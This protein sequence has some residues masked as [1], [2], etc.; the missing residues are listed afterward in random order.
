MAMRVM[1][2]PHSAAESSW[3]IPSRSSNSPR[4]DESGSGGQT[5]ADGPARKRFQKSTVASEASA[6]RPPTHTTSSA[7]VVPEPRPNFTSRRRSIRD[8]KNPLGPRLADFSPSKSDNYAHPFTS[9]RTLDDPV[10]QQP[11]RNEPTEGT[12]NALGFSTSAGLRDNVE[13]TAA[14]FDF[15]A[16]VS[17]DELH[18][19][20]APNELK[21]SQFPAPGGGGTI[22]PNRGPVNSSNAPQDRR[23]GG[24]SAAAASAAAAT[25]LGRSGS[26][27]RRQTAAARP[28]GHAAPQN[29]S[30]TDSQAGS[31]LS[32]RSRRQSHFVPSS[33]AAA[34]AR[35]PRKSIG[36]GV[37]D[38]A[39]ANQP[40]HPSRPS[41]AANGIRTMS[42]ERATRVSIG[43]TATAASQGLRL[44]TTSRDSKARSLQP[45]PPQD[46]H[47]ASSLTPDRARSSFIVTARSPGKSPSRIPTSP[48]SA[49]KRLSAMPVH[50]TGLG[51][52]T[53]S[54]TD[55][56]RMKRMSMMPEPPPMPS[57]PSTPP[58]P[59][60][61]APSGG[62]STAHSP[63]L[64]PRKSVTP[65]S[66]RNTPD[67]H[68]KSFGS[69]PSNASHN[70]ATTTRAATGSQQQHR[71]SQGIATSRLPTPKARNVHS[72]AGGDED[73]E[74]PPVPAIPKAYESPKETN[75]PPFFSA[76]KS[77]LPLESGGPPAEYVDRRTAYTP[78]P[79]TT[80]R[81]SRQ[82]RGMAAGPGSDAEGK[83]TATPGPARK[84][85]QP[86][87]LPPLNVLPLSTPTVA[88]VAALHRQGSN[89]AEAR[90][91]TPP[92][93]LTAKTPS[94]PM[95]A[96]KVA[97][98]SQSHRD[99]A[100][101]VQR[102]TRAESAALQT[103]N[104][105][106][107]ADPAHD[108][109]RSGRHTMTPFASSSL[110]KS[111]ADSGYLRIKDSG[112]YQPVILG[113]EP[114]ASRP[115]GPRPQAS[116]RTLKDD[117]CSPAASPTELDT[118]S[119][120][121]S[122]R[123]R[124]SMGF[125]KSSSKN[126]HAGLDREADATV[127]PPRHDDMPPPRLPASATWSTST[128]P[129]P[130]PSLKGT[131]HLQTRRR[132]GSLS[133]IMNGHSRI[134]S[135]SWTS[136]ATTRTPKDGQPPTA[137]AAAAE[138][139]PTP[140]T[141]SSIM[142]PVHKMLGSKSSMTAVRPKHLDQNLDADD[143]SAEEEMR[144]L[145]SKRKNFEA[146][147]KEVDELR[148]RAV[149]RERIAP[150][151]ALR[152]AN[153]NIF[154]R[155]EIIDYKDIYFCGVPNAKKHV[156]DL[157][158]Q[159][160]NFGYDDDRGDYNIVNGDHLAYR[161]EI[162]DI[163][164]KGSF[165]QVVRCV[166]H[167]TG[168]LV[169]IKIIRNKKRF[170]QQALVE[171]SI[172]QKL[173]EWVSEG[174]PLGAGPSADGREQD[175]QNRHSMVSFTQSFYFRGH[176]C[177]STELLGMNLYE[178]IKS[179]NFQGFSLKLIRRFTKQ[180]LSSL[181]LLKSHRVIHCDLKPENVLLAHPVH[182]E[183]KVIDFGS[184]CFENEKVYTY[185]Q[186]RFYRSPEVI[187][188]MTYGLPIDMWSVGCILAELHTGYPIFPGENEQEQLACIMEIFGPPEKHL[189]ERST[190]K[191]LFFDSLGK[192]R[193]TVS[194]KGR[195]RRPSSK[196]LQ[197]ALKCDDDAFLDFLTKCLRWDP[198]R[199]LKP[200]EAMMHEFVTR[201]KKGGRGGRTQQ[202]AGSTPVKRFNSITTLSGSRPLPE[203]PATSFKM[204][205]ARSRDAAVPGGGP[206]PAKASAVSAA[207]RQSTIV[208][209]VSTAG[210]KRSST[211]QNLSSSLPRVTPRS[212]SNRGELAAAAATVATNANAVSNPCRE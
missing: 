46:P 50:A 207:K 106:T 144:K 17:F 80:D 195:R 166:D 133:N 71:Y 147:A 38:T 145:A 101:P 96:S 24:A 148:R 202:L 95:T 11:P 69:G 172:L 53:I 21:L 121:S 51:A 36:P 120:G 114:R 41:L 49:S 25:R 100:T 154:E 146:A 31:S 26:L 93:R 210:I 190:R 2:Q 13:N 64:I 56:R 173:R 178:F 60:L 16:S 45:P 124:L 35:Q 159:T 5:A 73:E 187:L 27:L 39:L 85:S 62:R 130:S 90:A 118:P 129:S 135:D 107:G 72:S 55:A 83:I 37:L 151:N 105:S 104:A 30:A 125:K 137:A 108:D 153:L 97:F 201:T 117:P 170:H 212:T 110:P 141:A 127:Q 196:T 98:F 155:G 208:A 74:V 112:E 109:P 70:G 209:P 32:V 165:G 194:S 84:S 185:I 175:P 163:L 138:S 200:D 82:T 197:Q 193:L 174:K 122:L 65:S 59:L 205:T 23:D 33:T 162:V 176:L 184:S 198:E 66:A 68:R 182:S 43:P 111:A 102:G 91:T 158:A 6:R 157:A 79:S 123:Q 189:I 19:S 15:L 177:I 211:G 61:D 57:T 3:G 149:P 47:A 63:S 94:T 132:Q 169:A 54:P 167:K 199:R 103:A 88:K 76:R 67:H 150:T 192:P 78:E 115:T 143:L 7:R 52:R 40:G 128:V 126:L 75:A 168:G 161:Y 142:S 48:T 1:P 18:S 12:T 77:S 92:L 183:I 99:D 164:G 10:A 179:N 204:S 206:S 86:M 87:R 28:A 188:G 44:L 4:A 180:L 186:S 58:T 156:G 131:S 9:A 140:S 181:V 139:T 113:V 22:L 116:A 81:A 34:A 8:Q 119:S 160:A 136:R 42:T 152:N 134:M 191:K 14:S 203:P 89:V 171:V 20:I 29:A